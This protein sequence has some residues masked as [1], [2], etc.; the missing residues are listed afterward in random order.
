MII[1]DEVECQFTQP[2]TVITRPAYT[3]ACA[4]CDYILYAQDEP[5]PIVNDLVLIDIKKHTDLRDSVLD[6][7]CARCH[8]RISYKS[9]WNFIPFTKIYDPSESGKKSLL[10][11][12]TDLANSFLVLSLFDVKH[13]IVLIPERFD[14]LLND[15]E[16]L[17]LTLD[18]IFSDSDYEIDS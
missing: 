14:P 18:N 1:N 10:D 15:I 11:Q 13:E 7:N 2:E 3:L 5:F 17:F 4:V 8:F 12:C 16:L 9:I 6:I